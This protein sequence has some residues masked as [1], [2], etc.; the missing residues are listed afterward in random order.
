[1]DD[2][3]IPPVFPVRV[4]DCGRYRDGGPQGGTY[5]VDLMDSAGN[6]FPFF[7]DRFLGR[8]CYGTHDG[9]DNAAFIRKGSKLESEAFAAIEAAALSPEFEQL[10]DRLTHARRWKSS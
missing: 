8:L 6:V 9:T 1:M 2:W 7:F 10:S 5:F 4:S 3:P